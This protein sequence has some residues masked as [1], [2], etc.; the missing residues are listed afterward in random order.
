MPG[1]TLLQPGGNL[2]EILVGGVAAYAGAHLVMSLNFFNVQSPA[3]AR[4]LVV[5]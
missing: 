5:T 1:L 3:R 2:L 4:R